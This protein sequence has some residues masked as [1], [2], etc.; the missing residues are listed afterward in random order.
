M[1]N[2]WSED[3]ARLEDDA[4]D[5]ARVVS[6]SSSTPAEWAQIIEAAL[7]GR[8]RGSHRHNR[9][10]GKA[11]CPPK[12]VHGRVCGHQCTSLS[13]RL[14]SAM[15]GIEAACR[16]LCRVQLVPADDDAPTAV[17]HCWSDYESWLH[18]T[19]ATYDAQYGRIRPILVRLTAGK[20]STGG[21]VSKRAFMK[22]AR[23]M[24]AAADHGTGR[25]SRLS[26][27]T[28]VEQTGLSLRQV[29]RSRTAMLLLGVAT[30][31][32]RGRQRTLVER[33]ASWRVGDRSRGWASVWA[34]HPP[35]GARPVDKPV[36]KRK[37]ISA[38]QS[39]M[40]THLGRFSRAPRK[41]ISS[42]SHFGLNCGKRASRSI[43]KSGVAG[44]ESTV[45]NQRGLILALRWLAHE[46]TPAWARRYSP[47]TWAE[48]L[49][50]AAEFDW[51]VEDLHR[52]LRPRSEVRH[53]L[54]YVRAMLDKVDLA[55]P[56]IVRAADA[57]CAE[58]AAK[59]AAMIE[60]AAAAGVAEVRQQIAADRIRVREQALT[61]EGRKSAMA[62]RRALGE[63]SDRRR[64]E[65]SEF[66]AGAYRRRLVRERRQ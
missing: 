1:T 21:G 26:N 7:G 13:P 12:A 41:E 61:G 57:A 62:Q 43:D 29:Q 66:D 30:E 9:R 28:L 47:N 3:I 45:P 46:R 44:W 39:K 27:R 25:N 48:V 6:A 63:A 8:Y 5:S 50:P 15:G 59:E 2:H 10:R 33:M 19:S 42:G 49:A 58:E 16:R 40:A 64:E 4:T 31:L 60:R 54:S 14:M 52:E 34:L 56:Q 51:I 55:G 23:V 32:L 17:V 35:R 65:G 24:A 11:K 38:G 22:V 53:P 18:T 37:R 36:D 20:K